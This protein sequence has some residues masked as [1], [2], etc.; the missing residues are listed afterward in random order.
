MIIELD[1]KIVTAVK[2]ISTK[3]DLIEELEKWK[4]LK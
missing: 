2:F 4:I 3:K 1:K